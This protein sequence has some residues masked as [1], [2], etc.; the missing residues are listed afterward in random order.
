MENN[1]IETL[2]GKRT[3]QVDDDVT[4]FNE[5]GGLCIIRNK[6]YIAD[7]NNH[8]VKVLQLD[9]N[10]FSSL[11]KFNL[12]YDSVD[13]TEM[14][15]FSKLD[16][17]TLNALKVNSKGGKIILKLKLSFEEGMA[18]ADQAPQ[19]WY[20][21]LPNPTWSCVPNYGSNVEDIE[22]FLS[23]SE[24]HLPKGVVNLVYQIVTCT[25]STCTPKNFVIS[26]GI[27][28]VDNGFFSVTNHIN[29]QVTSKEIKLL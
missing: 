17:L 23:I 27:T 13:S 16:K 12:K 25:S 3:T 6:L 19:K 14:E 11:L 22:L 18:L 5:P 28:F 24:S 21:K 2:C 29:V 20:V 8:T 9:N 1:S 26:Q 7:T 15:T 4:T 10:S